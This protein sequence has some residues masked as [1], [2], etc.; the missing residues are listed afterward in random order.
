MELSS[1]VSNTVIAIMSTQ[2]KKNFLRAEPQKTTLF[3]KYHVWMVKVQSQ[4]EQT[5]IREGLASEGEGQRSAMADEC[6]V[7]INVCMVGV[8]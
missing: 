3:S 5:T 7:D 2:Y 6:E 1:E 4:C 8:S